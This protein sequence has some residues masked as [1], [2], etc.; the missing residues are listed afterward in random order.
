MFKRTTRCEN[1]NRK[2]KRKRVRKYPWTRNFADP[3][4]RCVGSLSRASFL[5]NPLLPRAVTIKIDRNEYPRKFR[6]VEAR[7]ADSAEK[8]S[9]ND[10]MSLVAGIAAT[11]KR[12]RG[13]ESLAGGVRDRDVINSTAGRADTSLQRVERQ[14]Q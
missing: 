2:R 9:L 10:E 4:E 7:T 12:V 6:R 8:I 1:Y 13:V 14:R 3:I 11:S 5:E